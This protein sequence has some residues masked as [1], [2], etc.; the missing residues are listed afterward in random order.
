MP[1]LRWLLGGV[2]GGAIGVAVWVLVGHAT[3]HE[4]GWIAWGIGFLTGAGVRFGARL[5]DDT[6]S[7]MRGALAAGI[8]LASIVTAK[9]L[10]FTLI[11][12]GSYEEALRTPPDD[13]RLIAAVADEIAREMLARGESVNWPAGMTYEKAAVQ[14][15]YPPTVWRQAESRWSALEPDE[16]ENRRDELLAAVV[17]SIRETPSP[18]FP[19]RFSASDLLWIGLATFTAFKLAAG[20]PAE[21]EPPREDPEQD[22]EKKLPEFLKRKTP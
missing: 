14:D 2:I 7:A 19:E 22:I 9:F 11:V 18:E 1:L 15:D 13:R 21:D 10:V 5:G 4:Y 3:N 6:G 16:Q 17:A 12:V 8:A 20:S